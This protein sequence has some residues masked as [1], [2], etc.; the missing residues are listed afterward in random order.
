MHGFDS[1][2]RVLHVSKNQIETF[3]YVE[4]DI[5]L[6]N[7]YSIHV[8]FTKINVLRRTEFVR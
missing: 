5:G 6:L 1:W 4:L 7:L 3:V 2:G 8:R